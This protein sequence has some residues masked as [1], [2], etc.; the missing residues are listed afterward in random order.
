MPGRLF[1]SKDGTL[2][3]DITLTLAI[4]AALLLVLWR[5]FFSHAPVTGPGDVA[6]VLLGTSTGPTPQLVER[7][8]VR[9]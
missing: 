3:R 5:L 1:S 8:G 7:E 6:D 4:K 2:A 9:R